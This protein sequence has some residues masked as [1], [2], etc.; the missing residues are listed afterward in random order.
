MGTNL[1][2]G[3]VP[4]YPGMIIGQQIQ[5]TDLISKANRLGAM[6]W[7]E[8]KEKHPVKAQPK[9]NSLGA[10]GGAGIGVMVAFAVFAAFTTPGLGQ[11]GMA[12]LLLS[13]AG[14]ATVGAAVGKHFP[15]SFDHQGAQIDAY[16]HYLKTTPA[17]ETSHAIAHDVIEE[18]EHSYTLP[19][20]R[21][22]SPSMSR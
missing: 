11:L 5:L 9:W 17:R 13:V 6:G 7:D 3:M 8:F 1:Y 21:P 18:K 12:I 14:G 22:V 10:V 4:S 20:R 2:N 19:P 16:E 15:T